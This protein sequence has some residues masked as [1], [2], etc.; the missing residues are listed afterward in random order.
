M[1]TAEGLDLLAVEV[2]S[3]KPHLETAVEVCLREHSLGRRTGFAFLDIDNVDEWPNAERTPMTPF[4]D[5]VR[6]GGRWRR[7]RYL[8]N[9]LRSKNVPAHIVAPSEPLRLSSAAEGIDSAETLR[10][11]TYR[12]ADLGLGALSSLIRITGDLDPEIDRHRYL[13]DRLL[14]SAC[15]SFDLT[16]SLIEHHCPTKVLVFNGRFATPR[17]I[18][19][20]ARLRGVDV[21]YHEVSSTPDRYYLS[22]RPPQSAEH[23]REL[24]RQGWRRAGSDRES[25]GA[26]FFAPA[27]GG[28]ILP[29]QHYLA[30]QVAGQGIPRAGRFRIVYYASSID[31]FA[32][33]DDGVEHTVF[34]SQRA[35]VE[36]LCSW[37]RGRPDAELILRLHPKMRSMSERELRW[38]R[39]FDSNNIR[40]LE[41]DSAVDSYALAGTADRVVC[42][43]SSMGVEATYLG[44]VSIL[45]G[46]ADYRGLD[47]VYEPRSTEE[48]ESLLEYG[49]VSAKPARNCLPYGFDRMTRGTKYLFYQPESYTEGR[50]FGRRI[51]ASSVWVRA[52][53]K[54]L[55]I[56]DRVVSPLAE[57]AV[58]GRP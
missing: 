56:V 7:V 2:T 51:P 45:V 42:Y 50:F 1:R 28:A 54:A 53:I 24:L 19:E 44:R 41:P 34:E 35:A 15:E 58:N 21:L 48:L 8:T 9:L 30:G 49:D 5:S 36:W 10:G 46:D 17:G 57:Q 52:R 27:R 26:R 39:S 6:R 43:H 32:S 20:A 16:T 33:I 37:V 12:G 4:I 14:N 3:W 11:F 47:C 13:V 55:K 23:S 25:V 31:E 29:S 22:H 18:A 40:V 38:W